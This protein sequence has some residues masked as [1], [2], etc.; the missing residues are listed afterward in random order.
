[1]PQ[2]RLH[3][4]TK[5]IL[6]LLVS[7]LVMSAG[8]F[9]L[10]YK[11]L[12]DS[13]LDRYH[14]QGSFL[15]ETAARTIDKEVFADLASSLVDTTAEF[16]DLRIY[17]YRIKESNSVENFYTATLGSDGESLVYVV[18]GNERFSDFFVPPG[19]SLEEKGRMREEA[20]I[21]FTKGKPMQ[22]PPYRTVSGK[23]LLS[24]YYPIFDKQNKVLGVVGCDFDFKEIMR[25]VYNQLILIVITIS[26]FALAT[27][28]AILIFFRVSLIS[29]VKSIQSFLEHMASGNLSNE[30]PE[31]LRERPDEIGIIVRALDN[32]RTSF[33]EMI[34]SVLHETEMLTGVTQN[35]IEEI[36][37]LNKGINDIAETTQQISAGMEE[38]AASSEE[39]EATAN[40]IVKS[41][42]SIAE[43][44]DKGTV[45]TGE[46]KQRA[47]SLRGKAMESQ[48]SGKSITE[49]VNIKLKQAIEQSTSVDHINSL[50]DSILNI[51]EQTNLLALNAAIEAARAGD[52]GKGFTVVADEIMKLATE[53]QETAN[54]IIDVTKE[55]LASVSNLTDSSQQVLDYIDKF[56]VKDY[57]VMVNTG[58]QYNADAQVIEEITTDFHETS[59]QLLMSIQHTIKAIDE[60]SKSAQEGSEE[61]AQIATNTTILNEKANVVM[62]LSQEVTETLNKLS[63]S[64]QVFKI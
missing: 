53:S 2:L 57:E 31:N 55:V 33:R 58:K 15:V 14:N 19:V 49:D 5:I 28:I 59:E 61:T 24:V 20:L 46:I 35:T 34:K 52:S 3:F 64:L 12:Y 6:L 16:D 25:N 22:A 27:V 54:Q 38:T 39:M 44:A 40:Q 4:Q 56:V 60:I 26:V 9:I 32:A 18:D 47:L 37:S 36:N 63:K 29:A 13:M 42:E 48:E 21:A 7:F 1:M 30:F 8:I 50:A 43:K 45:V 23:R 62:H 10:T 51:T 41:I 17:L 11:I